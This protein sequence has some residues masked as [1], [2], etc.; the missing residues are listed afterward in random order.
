MFIDVKRSIPICLIA[1]LKKRVLH[2]SLNIHSAIPVHTAHNLR[3]DIVGVLVQNLRL[4]VHQ[5]QPLHER[6][7]NR[8]QQVEVDRS[9]LPGG[10]GVFNRNSH[11][12]KRHDKMSG[13]KK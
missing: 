8:S 13:Q 1:A 5:V 4:D 3:E 6:V 2:P 7:Q 12:R 9:R 11:A 10:N